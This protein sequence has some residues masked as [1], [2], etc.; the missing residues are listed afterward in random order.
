[1]TD[2]AGL[3]FEQYMLRVRSHGAVVSKDDFIVGQC[4]GRTT[5]DV[6]CIDHSLEKVQAQG[7]TWLHARIAG[8]AEEVIGVD[9]LSAEA[10]FLNRHGYTI[11]VADAQ[12]M[13]LGRRFELIVLADVVEHVENP[14]LLLSTAVRHLEPAGRIILSTPN[15]FFA[16]RL[17]TALWA[18]AVG[19]NKEHVVWF[20]PQVAYRLTQRLGLAV[21]DFR[22]VSPRGTGIGSLPGWKGRAIRTMARAI[23]PRRPICH[24]DFILVL[25]RSV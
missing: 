25:Q 17:V 14:G 22:W 2:L 24:S 10:D 3:S 5:L 11:V 16:G 7:A 18:N 1:M 20:D 4:R 15:P 8:V 21:V 6:G 23:E 12:T 13:D 9:I 19:V